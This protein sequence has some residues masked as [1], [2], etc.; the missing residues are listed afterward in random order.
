[1]TQQIQKQLPRFV[2]VGGLGFLVDIGITLLLI[3]FGVDALI[4]RVIAI[5]F[6]MLTTW[7]LN[8]AFT[9]G[10]SNTSQTREG[11]RYF[12]VAI[13]IAIVNYAIYASLLVAIPSMSPAI[14][15]TISVGFATV[16][17]FFGYRSF[18]FKSAA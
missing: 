12:A 9:F 13:S 17:S 7:R 8:R 14:A 6:A 4:A 11:M 16:L 15:I 10:A 3:G 2:V 1:M 5:A 18:A